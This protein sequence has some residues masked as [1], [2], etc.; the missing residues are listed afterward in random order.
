M[1]LFLILELLGFV[2]VEEYH[3]SLEVVMLDGAVIY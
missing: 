2:E 3:R 1:I